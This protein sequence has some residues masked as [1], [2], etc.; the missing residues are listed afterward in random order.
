M[1]N[2]HGC[3]GYASQNHIKISSHSSQNSYHQEYEQQYIGKDVV[4]M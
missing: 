1:L 4:G 3:K 2:I